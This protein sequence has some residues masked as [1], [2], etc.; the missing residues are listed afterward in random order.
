MNNEKIR[1]LM[2]RLAD[3]KLLTKDEQLLVL[4]DL[5]LANRRIQAAKLGLTM[6]D[7]SKRNRGGAA[8]RKSGR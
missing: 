8:K 6:A 2:G 4:S 5:L 1:S 7:E 3:D